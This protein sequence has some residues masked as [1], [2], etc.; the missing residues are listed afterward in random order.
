[1]SDTIPTLP[2]Y[3]VRLF[4]AV[5][6]VGSTAFKN[7]NSN[8]FKWQ[9]TFQKFYDE[10]PGLLTTKFDEVA[11]WATNLHSAEKEFGGPKLWKTIGDEIIFCCRLRSVCHLTACIEAFMSSLQEFGESIEAA[12]GLDTKGNAWVASFPTPNS[13][14]RPLLPNRNEC[15]SYDIISEELEIQADEEPHLFDF[16][17]KGI[18]SGFRISKNSTVNH[19]TVSPGLAILLIT[20]AE[21]CGVTQFNKKIRLHDAQ[22]FKGVAENNPY[23]VLVMDVYRDEKKAKLIE[24][25]TTLLGQKYHQENSCL[26][27]YLIDYLS[28]HSIEIPKL[29]I[30]CHRDLKDLGDESLPDF[31]MEFTEDWKRE[32]KEGKESYSDDDINT[33]ASTEI[34]EGSLNQAWDL[35]Q[36]LRDIK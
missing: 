13:S 32:V 18:D 5:D 7:R 17:G 20:G 8:P 3:R 30:I 26:K 25:Q 24:Q 22:I 12:C 29:P 2:E 16:L 6:L 1:M 11:Q 15:M 33:T 27:E 10:F 9:K 23:P 36:D 31:Y 28:A 34:K 21:N 4:L 14:I 35:L 19:L